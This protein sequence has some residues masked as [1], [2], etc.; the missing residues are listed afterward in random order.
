MIDLSDCT[1]TIPVRIESED[2]QNN[3]ALVLNYI[4]THFKTNVIICEQDSQSNVKSMWQKDWATFC[5]HMFLEDKTPLFHKTRC[6]NLMI[7]VAK[8]PIIISHDSDVL[9]FPEK[10]VAARD[11]IRDGVLDFCYPFDKPLHNIAKKYYPDL[12]D[13]YD[14]NLI[15]DKTEIPHLSPPPGGCFFINKSKFIEAGMENE[16]MVAYGPEDQERLLRLTK[17]GYKISRLHGI[18]YH[19][20]H[21]KINSSVENHDYSKSN[22]DEYDRIQMM[23]AI[24]LKNYVSKWSW[25][26]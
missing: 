3:L 21:V 23:N 9:L 16:H 2:R 19:M 15:I 25:K 10:Y 26:L 5:T 13:S 4:K 17:L 7:K 12:N 22:K 18:L 11:A 6:L 20:D 1:F 8:T 24:Q 14:L